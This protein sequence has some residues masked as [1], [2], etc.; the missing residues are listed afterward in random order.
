MSVCVYVCVYVAGVCVCV[1]G[2]DWCVDARMCVCV[3]RSQ[4]CGVC[5]WCVTSM[6]NSN[7]ELSQVEFRV[8]YP[9]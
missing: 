9:Y 3:C 4:M 5:D 2:G 7:I 8:R 1:W 6:K